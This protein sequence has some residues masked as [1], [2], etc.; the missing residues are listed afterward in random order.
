MAKI[1]SNYKEYKLD[2]GLFVVLQKTPTQ[3]VAGR[4]RVKH[5]AL[6]EKPGEEGLAHFLEHALMTGGSQKYNPNKAKEISGTFGYSNAFT[7]LE[8]TCFPVDMF[9]EDTQLFLEYISDSIFNPRFDKSKVE[10][11]RQRVLSETADEKSKPEFKDKLAY[12]EAFFGKSSPH[13]YEV[14]G[15]EKVVRSASTKDISDFHKRG[16]HPNNMD[17]ILVGALPKNIETLIEENFSRYPSGDVE[18]FEFPRNPELNGPTVLHSYAPERINKENPEQSSTTLSLIMFG[19]TKTEEDSYAT[20]MLTSILGGDST[21]RLFTSVSQIKGLAYG[22]NAGYSGNNNK[23]L[24]SI[25]GN[26]KSIKVDEA[27]DTIFEEMSKLQTNLVPKESLDRIKKNVRYNIARTF[28]T[29]TGQVDAI[30]TIMDTG[31][32]PEYHLKKMGEVTPEKIREAA[33]KYFPQSR[34]EGPYV[35][36]LRDPLKKE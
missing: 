24:I 33:I 18:K 3:T 5:G 28:E 9:T 31:L 14:L 26:I 2:N 22:I 8:K 35:L 29:N 32:T 20:T 11:E 36:S 21:S 10:Q 17:L 34:K 15:K 13:A 25:E 4:L 1:N 27:I 12:M 6:N 16:Y 30:E 23:G 19:P 7:T